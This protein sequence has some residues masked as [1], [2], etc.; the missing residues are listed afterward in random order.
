[1]MA[2]LGMDAKE[3][4][5]GPFAKGDVVVRASPQPREKKK[6]KR[7]VGKVVWSTPETTS[8]KFDDN[9][10]STTYKTSNLKKIIPGTNLFL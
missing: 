5:S 4:V 9:K 7:A 3:E 10:I 1:M 6:G 2:M 8:A